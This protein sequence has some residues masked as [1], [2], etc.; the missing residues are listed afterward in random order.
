MEQLPNIY[1]FNPTCEYAVANGNAS[2]QPNRLLQKMEKDLDVLPLFFAQPNDIV[3]VSKL[4]SEHF[5]H[6]LKKM[7]ISLPR[8]MLLEEALK[9]KAEGEK[10]NR[11]MPWGWSPTVHKLLEP[12]KDSCSPA[13]LKSPVANWEPAK[14]EF[15]SKKFSLGILQ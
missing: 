9:T 12:L 8:F 7:G 14:R 3:L 11:L 13:F 6:R 10:L 1:F 5:Q 15:Y 2:W 4:P